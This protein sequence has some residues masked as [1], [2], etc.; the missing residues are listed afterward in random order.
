MA[1]SLPPS[2]DDYLEIHESL[3][4]GEIIYEMPV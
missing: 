2:D 4:D 3:T 1:D